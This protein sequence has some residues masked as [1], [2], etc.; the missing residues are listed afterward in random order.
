VFA[1]VEDE[2]KTKQMTFMTKQLFSSSFFF[3]SLIAQDT[4]ILS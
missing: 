1:E 4:V 2:D 3:F